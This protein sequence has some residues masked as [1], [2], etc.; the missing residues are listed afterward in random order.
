MI[1]A[2]FINTADNVPFMRVYKSYNSF[3]AAARR[4]SGAVLDHAVDVVNFKIYRSI[5]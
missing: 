1:H 5:V 4:M 2:T 3:K